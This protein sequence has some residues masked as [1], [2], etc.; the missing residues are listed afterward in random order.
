MLST[1]TG[2]CLV[3]DKNTQKSTHTLNYQT[4]LPDDEVYA[5][6][7]DRNKGLWVLHEYGM[8]RVDLKLPVRNINNYPGLEGNLTSIIEVDSIIYVS[9]SEGVYYLTEVKKYDEIEVLVKI[10]E[11]KKIKNKEENEFIKNTVDADEKKNSGKAENESGEKKVGIFGKIFGKKNKK[12]KKGDPSADGEIVETEKQEPAPVNNP[13]VEDFV[14]KRKSRNQKIS[15]TPQS[16]STYEKQKNYALQ[17]ISHRFNKIKGIEGKAK[18]FVQFK[19]K[20]LVATNTGLYEI[21]NLKTTPILAGRYINYIHQAKLNLNKFYIGTTNGL[22][23]VEYKNNV[24]GITDNLTDFTENVYSILEFNK[25][26][27]IQV[28]L[29][30]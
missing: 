15:V 30:L 17:S 14:K 12:N 20:I 2:G 11:V 1:V 29:L 26:S 24:W 21:E 16:T 28:I 23:I 4:G 19:N 25:N 3:I 6:G 8:S 10:N 18:Q 7:I 22:L 27:V 5:L 9:T 13:V